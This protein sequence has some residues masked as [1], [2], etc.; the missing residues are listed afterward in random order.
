MFHGTNE[1][2]GFTGKNRFLCLIPQKNRLENSR[3]RV[4]S[5][6]KLKSIDFQGI[7]GPKRVT[8]FKAVIFRY[9][10]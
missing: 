6:L 8:F 1:R 2:A 5:V 10:T 4:K 7:Y 3:F 9:Q